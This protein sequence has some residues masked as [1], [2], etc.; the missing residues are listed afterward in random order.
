MYVSSIVVD[1][2]DRD[3]IRCQA[4]TAALASE[5][6][7]DI[8]ALVPPSL[9]HRGVRGAEGTNRKEVNHGAN[10]AESKGVGT[11]VDHRDK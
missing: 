11:D 3:L 2:A 8:P 4:G 1:T 10:G 7:P 9:H 6:S 5:Q